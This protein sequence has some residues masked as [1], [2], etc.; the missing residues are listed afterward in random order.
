MA[1]PV[2]P[3]DATP[4][5]TSASGTDVQ[6]TASDG[7]TLYGSF[8]A[9]D[10]GFQGEMLTRPERE[11]VAKLVR[12]LEADRVGL[13]GLGHDPG[14]AQR[15]KMGAHGRGLTSP[16]RVG[17]GTLEILHRRKDVAEML[18][19]MATAAAEDRSL[20]GRSFQLRFG[21]HR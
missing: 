6:I 7:K 9:V 10:L 17:V 19:V 1:T 11:S 12:N 4:A 15:I 3:Q 8:F 16:L 18:A 21:K 20:V 14:H 2:I 13:G 5:P